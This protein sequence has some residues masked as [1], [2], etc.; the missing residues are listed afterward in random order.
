MH[1][2]VA[3]SCLLSER[4]E[5]TW[6]TRFVANPY[7]FDFTMATGSMNLAWESVGGLTLRDETGFDLDRKIPMLMATYDFYGLDSMIALELDQ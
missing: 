7:G 1:H 4:L 2:L 3:E 6:P 5:P